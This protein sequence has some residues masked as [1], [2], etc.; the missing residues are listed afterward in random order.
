MHDDPSDR[1]RRYHAALQPYR[2][3]LLE[4]MFAPDAVYVSAGVAGRIEGRA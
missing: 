3:A 4:G 1:L 2:R